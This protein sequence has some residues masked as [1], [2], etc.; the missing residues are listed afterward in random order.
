MRPPVFPKNETVLSYGL[1][2]KL[3]E[4]P[5]SSG[6]FEHDFLFW[7][8][9]FNTHFWLDPKKKIFGIFMTQFNPTR[10]PVAEKIDDL[11]DNHF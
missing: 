6:K 4:K 3:V 10:Y 9:A 1:G 8:G 7:S 5:D 11:L 2:I